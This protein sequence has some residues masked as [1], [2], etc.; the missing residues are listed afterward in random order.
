M[1]MYWCVHWIKSIQNRLVASFCVCV[2]FLLSFSLLLKFFIFENWEQCQK[3]TIYFAVPI[4]L[5][6]TK[7]LKR[8]FCYGFKIG[9]CVY[10]SNRNWQWLQSYSH[11]NRFNTML[12]SIK[13]KLR[14]RI[15]MR[16]A[17]FLLKITM[18]T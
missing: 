18:I 12:K 4:V 17:L 16:N 8:L 10:I 15:I 13:Y 2:F 5:H 3:K 6:N 1:C 9:V 7:A 14:E 11:S